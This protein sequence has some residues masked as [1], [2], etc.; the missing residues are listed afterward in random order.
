MEHSKLYTFGHCRA[1]ML[2]R[3]NSTVARFLISHAIEWQTV[4]AAIESIAK[5]LR[6]AAISLSLVEPSSSTR[7]PAFRNGEIF[8]VGYSPS[9]DRIACGVFETEDSWE[10]FTSHVASVELPHEHASRMYFGPHLPS[11]EWRSRDPATAAE[12]L[13]FARRQVAH[14]RTLE[15]GPF[16]GANT[17][18]GG[19][20]LCCEVTRDSLQLTVPGGLGYPL[21]KETEGIARRAVVAAACGL[22]SCGGGDPPARAGEGPNIA[23]GA[24]SENATGNGSAVGLTV[25]SGVA[26]GAVTLLTTTRNISLSILDIK[27]TG[28]FEVALKSSGFTPGTYDV[29]YWANVSLYDGGGNL[30]AIVGGFL[31]RRNESCNLSD[32]KSYSFSIAKSIA[33]A[34]GTDSTLRLKLNVN[35][36]DVCATT[37]NGGASKA[38]VNTATVSFDASLSERK[39]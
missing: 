26:G 3:G 2:V 7:H 9:L 35:G 33:P 31:E 36:I 15:L 16:Q 27:V 24:I 32:S 28:Q 18:F 5:L 13:E 10:T 38:A 12:A 20:F 29:I 25:T 37:G 34:D 19:N 6:A 21:A 8:L 17:P 23:A 22:L 11:S 30:L 14:Q 1:V 4:D 39:R